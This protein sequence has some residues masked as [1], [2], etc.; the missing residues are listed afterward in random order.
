MNRYGVKWSTL[1]NIIFLWL[2]LTR[3]ASLAMTAL[4]FS[5]KPMAL[6]QQF[7]IAAELMT[8]FLSSPLTI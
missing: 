8:V 4:F 3:K 2:S 7:E 6:P 5:D 1:E